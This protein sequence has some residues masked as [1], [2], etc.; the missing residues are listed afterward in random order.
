MHTLPD[1]VHAALLNRVDV[2]S[3][4][5]EKISAVAQ[6]VE[7]RTVTQPSRQALQPTSAAVVITASGILTPH[8]TQQSCNESNL[9]V[10]P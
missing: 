2:A 8:F 3:A 1:I 7:S 4:G 5:R 10:W 9:Q 6:S